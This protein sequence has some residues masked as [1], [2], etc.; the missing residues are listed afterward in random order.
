VTRYPPQQSDVL[1]TFVEWLNATRSGDYVIARRP[2]LTERTRPDIDYVLTNSAT[3]RKIAVEV[4]STWRSQDAGREDAEWLRW[5]EHVRALVRGKIP[6][7]FRVSTPLRISRDLR[8]DQFA[9]S[10]GELLRQ[11]G[12]DIEAVGAQG[13]YV[14]IQVQ[15]IDVNV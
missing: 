15:G 9:E 7:Q 4:S 14:R 3:G 2:D 6:G 10:L 5:T 13:K 1:Q 11:K 8:P 12:G